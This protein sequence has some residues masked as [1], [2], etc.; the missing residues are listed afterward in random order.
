MSENFSLSW[1]DQETSPSFNYSASQLSRHFYQ[2][3][4]TLFYLKFSLTWILEI[5]IGLPLMFVSLL[6]FPFWSLLP[7]SGMYYS[8]NPLNRLPAIKRP[9]SLSFYQMFDYLPEINWTKWEL[10]ALVC[11]YSSK[12]MRHFPTQGICL[13]NWGMW[14]FCS[15]WKQSVENEL[16]HHGL[17]C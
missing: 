12:L 17:V 14:S 9:S 11:I 7:D 3:V 8:P 10:W 6:P 13:N 16:C 5:K 15:P 4:C 1:R 2:A